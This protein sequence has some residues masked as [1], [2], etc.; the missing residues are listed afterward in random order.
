M[1]AIV[2]VLKLGK[3]GRLA[4]NVW[5]TSRAACW[6]KIEWK[7]WQ[8]QV[9]PWDIQTNLSVEVQLNSQSLAVQV[10]GK[11]CHFYFIE[12]VNKKN[13]SNLESH[14]ISI[15]TKLLTWG[16]R[17]SLLTLPSRRIGRERQR[18]TAMRHAV[19]RDR[20]HAPTVARSSMISRPPLSKLYSASACMT[21]FFELGTA[22]ESLL[23]VRLSWRAS[24]SPWPAFSHSLGTNCTL[25]LAPA[26]RRSSA[27]AIRAHLNVAKR[28][29]D[30][31]CLSSRV[32]RRWHHTSS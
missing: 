14:I 20:G 10:V 2:R 30:G 9:K 29:N 21:S 28:S 16:G 31:F 4:G 26:L 19:L 27:M 32:S 8:G 22:L 1:E 23:S 25:L 6:R 5:Y 24:W 15:A 11:S 7:E 13:G 17:G 18:R 12:L 3:V